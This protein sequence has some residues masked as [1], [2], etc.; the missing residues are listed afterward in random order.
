MSDPRTAAELPALRLKR[1]EDRRLNAGHLWIFSNE[2]DTTQTPLQRFQ[3]GDLVRVLA[4]NDRALGLAYVNPRSLIAA[5]MLSTW[6]PP[7]A[8]WLAGRIR[9][10]L[11]LRE[12]LYPEPYYRLVYGESDGLPGLVI[13]RY[14]ATCVAQIGTAGMERLKPEIHR[15][16]AEAVSCETLMFKNDGS[17]RELEGL[18]SYVETV[19]GAAPAAAAVIEDGL[20]FRAP[21][22]EGQ[23]TGWFFDQA[24]NRRALAK[25]LRKGARVLDV[26]SYVG[27]WGV[28]AA[29]AGA[30]E[31]LCIDSS[32][33]ALNFAAQNAE[34]NGVSVQT[35]KRDA[36]DALE[37]LVRS[38]ARYDVVVIDPPAFAKRKKDLPKALAAYKRL[39]QLAMKA[40]A[41]DAIL[42][43]CSCSHHVSAEDLQD[44]IG[45]A[46]RAAERHLQILEVGG[47]AADHPVHPAI[48]ETRYLKT[49]FCRVGDGLK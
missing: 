21:L 27:A 24:A 31:V 23:K 14:G 47:Q 20:E 6:T 19:G 8:A 40:L 11:D 43:S 42:V 7:T 30:G 15:A 4:H 28:R 3:P 1:N 45:K 37:E 41:H 48:P 12:R 25:Y 2:I 9:T 33:A 5:R 26:F 34:R 22:A 18:P 36:F 39:N 38:G 44:A 32:E 35:S 13:D 29:S 10:A 16:L 46:A 49:F 17:A